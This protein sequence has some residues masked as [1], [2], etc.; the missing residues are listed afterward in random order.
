MS[1]PY[2]SA[3]QAHTEEFITCTIPLNVTGNGYGHPMLVR[4]DLH[5][6][7]D[8]SV[9]LTSRGGNTGTPIDK[10]KCVSVPCAEWDKFQSDHTDD[11]ALAR[12]AFAKAGWV[13][14]DN[15]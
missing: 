15:E 7:S 13:L 10:A 9:L 1:E 6:Q 11:L 8:D 12:W 3:N 2:K 4:I 5:L 14:R